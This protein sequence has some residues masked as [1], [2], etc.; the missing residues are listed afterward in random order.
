MAD[1][2]LDPQASPPENAP[3]WLKTLWTNDDVKN[4]LTGNAP[5]VNASLDSTAIVGCI[6]RN[7]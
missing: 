4:V 6:G 5:Q 7:Q 3:E 1:R 2:I